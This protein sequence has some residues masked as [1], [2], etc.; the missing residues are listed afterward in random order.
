VNVEFP[1]VSTLQKNGECAV[2]KIGHS[3]IL[4]AVAVEVRG[5]DGARLSANRIDVAGVLKVSSP[6][7]KRIL[8]SFAVGSVIRRS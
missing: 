7:L 4:V 6:L 8:T 3:E 5:D 2:R 1:F